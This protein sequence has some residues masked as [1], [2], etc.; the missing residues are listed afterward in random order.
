MDTAPDTQDQFDVIVIGGALSG[1]STAFLLKRR[2]PTLRIL[3]VEKN[4]AFKRR[5]GEATTEV[6]GFFLTRMLGLT[7]YLIRTQIPKN[8]L[9][10]WFSQDST[11]DAAD[12]SELGGRYLSTVPAFLLDRSELDEEVLR[13]A[14]VTGIELL[15]PARVLNVQ[16]EEGGMQEVSIQYG[17]ETKIFKSRWVVDASG[18][19]AQLARANRWLHTNEAHPTLAA[20]SRWRNT[21]D[22]DGLDSVMGSDSIKSGFFGIRGTATNHFAGDGWWAW[23]IQLKNGDVSI[24]LV[25]DQ[26]LVDWS[27]QEGTVGEKLHRFLSSHPAACVMM[28]DAEFID[29]DVHFRRNLPYYSERQAGDGFVLVGDASAFI[30]PLYSPG[31][32]WIAFTASAAVELIAKCK[33][34][35]NPSPLV[36]KHNRDFLISYQR[37]FGALYQ[38]KYDYLGDFD[39]M[40]VSFRLDIV[41]YYLYVVRFLYK[42]GPQAILKP[43]FSPKEAGPFFRFMCFYNRRLAAMGRSR[44]ERGVF[45]QHNKDQRDLVSGFNFRLGQLFRT[46]FDGLWIWLKLELQEG[47]R[48][49]RS[50]HS[51]LER[52]G[53]FFSAKSGDFDKNEGF[54]V[55]G[56]ARAT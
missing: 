40:R 54:T 7:N 3:V 43:P 22:W 25:L 5:V 1:A 52:R 15:R 6:S 14:V 28:R 37:M 41:T 48:K 55:N 36:E 39:L 46:A 50:S 4:T 45:G 27:K 9:R 33:E 47:W 19:K 31:M 16:L 2:N 30:D 34:G 49:N 56:K 12:C 51:Q 29:G 10:F 13:R 23:W 18:V 24:G 38:D 53:R 32:D 21:G 8:G 35:E 20:W 42:N 44:R 26:R 11:G 17:G